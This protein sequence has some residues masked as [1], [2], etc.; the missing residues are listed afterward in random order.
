MELEQEKLNPMKVKQV[1]SNWGESHTH[2]HILTHTCTHTNWLAHTQTKHRHKSTTWNTWRNVQFACWDGF[3]SSRYSLSELLVYLYNLYFLCTVD[4]M[5]NCFFVCLG[6]GGGL[7]LT[8]WSKCCLY[9]VQLTVKQVKK[10]DKK[11]EKFSSTLEAATHSVRRTTV[12]PTWK[13]RRSMENVPARW[14][15]QLTLRGGCLWHRH[16]KWG[17][18]SR[19]PCTRKQ[20]VQVILQVPGH[21]QCILRNRLGEVWKFWMSNKDTKIFIWKCA[22]KFL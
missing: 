14:K 13:K 6:G 8:L 18:V 12:A 17:G 5:Y 7:K 15:L 1:P 20:V 10:K 2:T 19:F 11:K 22:H 21:R 3:V 16:R 4:I 9:F